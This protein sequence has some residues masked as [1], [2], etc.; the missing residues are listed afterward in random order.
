MWKEVVKRGRS[1]NYLTYL[2]TGLESVS[3]VATPSALI[4]CC[5]VGVADA[6]RDGPCCIGICI[7]SGNVS[8][9]YVRDTSIP[10]QFFKRFEHIYHLISPQFFFSFSVSS[11]PFSYTW[12]R[13]QSIILQLIIIMKLFWKFQMYSVSFISISNRV[14]DMYG[15]ISAQKIIIRIIINI[16]CEE[17]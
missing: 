1:E 8:G 14:I 4:R 6:I 15:F 7:C 5:I 3:G 9:L 10:L 11:T 13:L 2:L 12:L 17:R 16:N